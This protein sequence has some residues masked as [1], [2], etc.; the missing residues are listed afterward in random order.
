ML[1]SLIRDHLVC[2]RA[3]LLKGLLAGTGLAIGG[4]SRS[5]FL[6]RSKFFHHFIYQICDGLI[7]ALGHLLSSRSSLWV[8]VLR[9]TC[10]LLDFWRSYVS[11]LELLRIHVNLLKFVLVNS[12]LLLD[13]QQ[14]NL[15]VLLSSIERLIV[16]GEP[17]HLQFHLLV[18]LF[19]FCEKALRLFW[20]LIDFSI[21]RVNKWVIFG[22][23]KLHSSLVGLKGSSD[24]PRMLLLAPQIIKCDGQ[25][26]L[27]LFGSFPSVHQFLGIFILA[28]C[29]SFCV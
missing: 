10:T 15:S 22:S 9:W 26:R 19:K 8:I 25:E 18:R 27:L 6:H 23:L 28:Q 21:F 14:I 2:W 16:H 17:P 4:I 5:S 13:F 24:I 12:P 3:E 7:E 29:L 11:L 1:G 20:L